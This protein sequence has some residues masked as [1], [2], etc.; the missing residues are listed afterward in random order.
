LKGLRDR[1]YG[2][3][4]IASLG[5]LISTCLLLRRDRSKILLEYMELTLGTLRR[6][7]SGYWFSAMLLVPSE[8]TLKPRMAVCF[9]SDVLGEAL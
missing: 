6:L 8:L 4:G 1:S 9:S 2:S 7:M 5:D 3:T